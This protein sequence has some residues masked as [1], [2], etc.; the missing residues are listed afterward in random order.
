MQPDPF[1][2]P[3]PAYVSFSG[4]RTSGMMLYRIVQAF[5]GDLPSDVH[6]LFANTGKERPETLDFVRDCSERFGVPITWLEYDPDSHDHTQIV[7]YETANRNGKPFEQLIDK[8]SYL[9]NPVTR[10]CTI[11][12]KIRRFLKF[13][14]WQGYCHFNTAVGLRADEPQ[15]VLKTKQRNASGKERQFVFCPMSD[16]NLTK[17]DVADFWRRQNFDLNLPNIAGKTPHGNCDLCFLKGR[18]TIIRMIS[19]VPELADWWINQENRISSLTSSS[20][21]TFRPAKDRE[22]YSSLRHLAL[23]QSDLVDL[24]AESEALDCACTD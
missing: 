12:L 20:G 1:L 11:E 17:R 19:D 18:D 2:I 5:G 10:F 7:T 6:V 15:R 16:A 21:G 3:R 22:K 24:A 4:G 13:M 23:S 14:G 9:P 8:R